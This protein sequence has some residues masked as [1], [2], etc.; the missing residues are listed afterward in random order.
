MPIELSSPLTPPLDA[1][2]AV[3]VESPARSEVALDLPVAV[4]VGELVR[5]ARLLVGSVIVAR[6]PTAAVMLEN[7]LFASAELVA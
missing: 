6:S 5:P 3:D 7:S 1:A 4:A 2:T